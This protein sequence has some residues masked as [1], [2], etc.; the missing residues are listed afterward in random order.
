[1][2]WRDSWADPDG[3]QVVRTPPENYK[4]IGFLCNTGTG[5]LKNKNATEPAFNVGLSYAR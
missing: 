4:N 3:G 1:M 2:L 5:P